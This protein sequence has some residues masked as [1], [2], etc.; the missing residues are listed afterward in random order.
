MADTAVHDVAVTVTSLQRWLTQLGHTF[1]HPL[2]VDRVE[3]GQQNLTYP[4]A[5]R[6]D[7]RWVLR[8]PPLGKL[9]AS[10]HD[11]G[12]EKSELPCPDA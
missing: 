12:R 9:L 2:T 6:S 3:L 10:A 8:R 11:I 5:D 7:R 1:A 4:V